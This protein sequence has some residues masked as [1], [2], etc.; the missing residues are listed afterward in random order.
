MLCIETVRCCGASVEGVARFSATLFS[1]I[2]KTKLG[3]SQA[4]LAF[5]VCIDE[6]IGVAILFAP[7]YF[8]IQSA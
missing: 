1:V 3:A 4:D 6:L 5:A 8:S 2:L 7:N